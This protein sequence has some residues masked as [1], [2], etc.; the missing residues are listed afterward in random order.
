MTCQDHGNCCNNFYG[1]QTRGQ[2]LKTLTI[3]K[4]YMIN[5]FL[6]FH[7]PSNLSSYNIFSLSLFCPSGRK[8]GK[9]D[10][11]P[12]IHLYLYLKSSPCPQG[13]KHL[14]T[15]AGKQIKYLLFLKLLLFWLICLFWSLCFYSDTTLMETMKTP[16]S[17]C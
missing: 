11:F 3:D 5:L 6:H 12:F 1:F 4:R 9:G 7:I 17:F 14:N 2:H 15:K 8:H 13:L 16:K 10:N